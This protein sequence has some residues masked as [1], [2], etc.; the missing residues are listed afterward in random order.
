MCWGLQFSQR[1]RDAFVMCW[2]EGRCACIR[3]YYKAGRKLHLLVTTV[4]AA[5]TFYSLDDAKRLAI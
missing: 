3:H 4:L 2:L 5:A 1:I